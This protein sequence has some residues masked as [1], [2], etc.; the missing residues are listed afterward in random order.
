MNVCR[1]L[2]SG[3]D[4]AQY[5][6]QRAQ[7]LKKVR[8]IRWDPLFQHLTCRVMSR[9][10]PVTGSHA[11]PQLSCKTLL[12]DTHGDPSPHRTH[13]PRG[14]SRPQG[15]H[16]NGSSGPP[17]SNR[18]RRFYLVNFTPLSTSGPWRLPSASLAMNVYRKKID[19]PK[20]H[21]QP[22]FFAHILPSPAP[23]CTW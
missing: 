9:S 3:R 17:R 5:H 21:G 23:L 2:L 7:P 20:I 11:F 15:A 14:D 12:S 8:G 16:L 22:L 1:L 13:I 6:N 19:T 10:H 18:R 4:R